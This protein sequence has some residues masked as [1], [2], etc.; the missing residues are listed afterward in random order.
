[1]KVI[2]AGGRDI[3]PQQFL[4]ALDF[5][6]DDWDVTEVVSGKARGVDRMGEVLADNQSIPV[7]P[8]PADWDK[9]DDVV[10]HIRNKEMAIYANSLFAIWNGKS[11][12]T[13]NMINIATELGLKFVVVMINKGRI[14]LL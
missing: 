5:F 12:G 10:G 6:P 1:M 7:K 8:F 3:T 2:I 13:K 14:Y 9:Y 4:K 11:K